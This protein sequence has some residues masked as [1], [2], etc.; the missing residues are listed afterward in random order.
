[1]RNL[2]SI[3]YGQLGQTTAEYALILLVVGLA[4]GAFATFVKGGA[5]TA[6]FREIISGLIDRANG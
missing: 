1:M 6:L 4:V 2:R 5:L 3:V